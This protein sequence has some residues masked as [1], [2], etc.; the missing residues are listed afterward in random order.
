MKNYKKSEWGSPQ[1]F[2]TLKL[3]YKPTGEIK[4][5]TLGIRRM[6]Y[7]NELIFCDAW[8]YDKGHPTDL[9]HPD[10]WEIVSITPIESS[11]PKMQSEK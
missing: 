10:N 7:A 9:N 1:K 11:E 2:G 6:S 3:R 8:G 5:L 4:E